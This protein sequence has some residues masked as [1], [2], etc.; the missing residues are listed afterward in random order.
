M[1]RLLLRQHP[2]STSLTCIPL[3]D[4]SLDN[5][6]RSDVLLIEAWML[7]PEDEAQRGRALAAAAGAQANRELHKYLMD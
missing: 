7:W 4:T 6:E 3:R 1:G 5:P 2:V